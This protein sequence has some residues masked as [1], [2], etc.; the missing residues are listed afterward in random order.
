MGKK[1][2]AHMHIFNNKP[3]LNGMQICILSLITYRYIKDIKNDIHNYFSL[4]YNVKCA[5]MHTI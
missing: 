4:L 3:S 2:Y 5:I 1:Q